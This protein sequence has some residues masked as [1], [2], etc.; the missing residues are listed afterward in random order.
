MSPGS[1]TTAERKRR[2]PKS[3]KRIGIGVP[4]GVLEAVEAE[5]AKHRLWPK[6]EVQ[7]F[8]IEATRRYITE[9]RES[10]LPPSQVAGPRRPRGPE[11]DEE[12][13][14]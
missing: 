13:R 8:M 10:P 12:A 5:V 2:T 11:P 4:F 1:T 3:T 14:R 7:N 6:P 9:L